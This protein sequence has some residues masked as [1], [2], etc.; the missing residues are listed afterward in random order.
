MS[1][2]EVRIR[3]AAGIVV[4]AAFLMSSCMDGPQADALRARCHSAQAHMVELQ[5]AGLQASGGGRPD[6]T[7]LDKHRRLL[8]E[9]VGEALVDSCIAAANTARVDCMLASRTTADMSRCG[10]ELDDRTRSER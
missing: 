8:T 3:A 6:P 7:E 1:S 4:S 9:H 2:S 5:L 10:A